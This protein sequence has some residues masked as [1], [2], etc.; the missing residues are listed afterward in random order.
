MATIRAMIL[1]VS[2]MQLSQATRMWLFAIGHSRNITLNTMGLHDRL[3]VS[4][5]V[6]V[7]KDGEYLF[8]GK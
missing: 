1:E 4:A 7:P 2:A 5:T 6:R 3:N 8:G